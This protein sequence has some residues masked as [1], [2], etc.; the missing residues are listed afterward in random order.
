MV[1]HKDVRQ[2]GVGRNERSLRAAIIFLYLKKWTWCISWLGFH[3]SRK[4]SQDV[5]P[6]WDSEATGV[7]VNA[8]NTVR[9]TEGRARCPGH[10]PAWNCEPLPASHA[11]DYASPNAFDDS[12]TFSKTILGDKIF[13][14]KLRLHEFI[15]V[16]P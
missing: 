1:I 7:K 9:A 8:S 5:D 10:K 11:T 2:F 3:L 4:T 15:R 13:R 16:G 6:S 14:R 12:L